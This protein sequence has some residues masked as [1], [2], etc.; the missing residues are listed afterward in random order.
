MSKKLQEILRKNMEFEKEAPYNFCDR[1]CKRCVY[2]KQMRCKV[3]QDELECKMTC[4]AHGREPDDPEIT[5]AVLKEQYKDIDEK[6]SRCMD[7]FGI[8]IDNPDIDEDKFDEACAVNF[9]GLPLDIQ[10]HI[11][12]VENNSLDKAAENYCHKA[13]AFLKETFYK[14]ES[15]YSGLKYDFETVSWYHTLLPAK[16]HRALCGFHE[17]ASEGDISLYDAIAQLQ[18]CKKAITESVDAL[19][20]INK[21]YAPF[22]AQIQTILA[23]IHNIY[24]R[25][26]KLEDGIA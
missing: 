2:E 20:K 7:K 10:K 8:D 3:Y 16:L 15:A 23:L 14:N 12:F 11:R 17:P 22:R 21:N 24:D 1:W 13:Y 18:I 9:E 26:K 4:I 5:E 6:L 25:I 19:R